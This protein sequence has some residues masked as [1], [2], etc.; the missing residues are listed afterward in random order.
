LSA[1]LA[2]TAALTLLAGVDRSLFILEFELKTRLLRLG[3]AIA[4]A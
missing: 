4:L 3:A 2:L 1:L